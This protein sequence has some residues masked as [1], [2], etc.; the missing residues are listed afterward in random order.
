M[1]SLPFCKEK[2]SDEINEVPKMVLVFDGLCDLIKFEV[3]LENDPEGMITTEWENARMEI[4]NTM[5]V[6]AN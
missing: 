4:A 3:P 1:L 6:I 5:T 2:S